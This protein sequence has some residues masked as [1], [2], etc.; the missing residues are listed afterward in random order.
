[1]NSFKQNLG[2]GKHVLALPIDREYKLDELFDSSLTGST[3]EKLKPNGTFTSEEKVFFEN[4]EF[5]V[6][7]LYKTLKPFETI[8]LTLKRPININWQIAFKSNSLIKNE[9]LKVVQEGY[10]KNKSL[11]LMQ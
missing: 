1:M 10:D 7:D 5:V 8:R 11:Q 3:I 4:N 9:E 6:S 2:T